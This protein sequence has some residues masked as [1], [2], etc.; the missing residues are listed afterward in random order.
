MKMTLHTPPPHPAPHP[1]HTNSML[2]T[3]QLL[4]TRFWWNFKGRFLWTYS[5]CHGDICPGNI[6][7]GDIY[8]Y[9]KYL[10]YYWPDLNENLKVG[11]WYLLEQIPTAMVTFSQATFV[12]ESYVHIR[13]IYMGLN[14]ITQHFGLLNVSKLSSISYLCTFYLILYK[15]SI[16]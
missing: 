5:N 6:C 15:K 13:N 11:S 4:L 8:P 14:F 16:D 12:L 7:P 3:S 1:P 2:A 10:R 9:Q